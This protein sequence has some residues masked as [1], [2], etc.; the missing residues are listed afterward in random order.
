M[1]GAWKINLEIMV[2]LTNDEMLL[3]ILLS[4]SNSGMAYFTQMWYKIYSHEYGIKF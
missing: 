4:S 3:I 2:Q 1:T